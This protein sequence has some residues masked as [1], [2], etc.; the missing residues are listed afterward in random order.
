MKYI[1][2]V[3]LALTLVSGTKHHKEHHK[4]PQGEDIPEEIIEGLKDLHDF[5]QDKDVA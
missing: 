5:L 3:A 2:F 4:Y 1:V